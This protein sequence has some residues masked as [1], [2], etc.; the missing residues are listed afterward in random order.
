MRVDAVHPELQRV[1]PTL[2]VQGADLDPGDE[3]EINLAVG[4]DIGRFSARFVEFNRLPVTV[5]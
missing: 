1:R 4:R 2:Q 3:P 5:I